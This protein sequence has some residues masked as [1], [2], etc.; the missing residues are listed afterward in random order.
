[1]S[2]TVSKSLCED[3]DVKGCNSL[4]FHNHLRRP[5]ILIVF[6]TNDTVEYMNELYSK[7]GEGWEGEVD[8]IVEHDVR[9]AGNGAR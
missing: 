6:C 2:C 8:G 9:K 4:V 1:M 3:G 5:A 7:V